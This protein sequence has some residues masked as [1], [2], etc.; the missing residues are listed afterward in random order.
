M[1]NTVLDCLGGNRGE[2]C[3]IRSMLTKSLPYSCMQDLFKVKSINQCRAFFFLC[4]QLKLREKERG[5]AKNRSGALGFDRRVKTKII[6][7]HCDA[8][9]LKWDFLK[10][11]PLKWECMLCV[12]ECTSS[13]VTDKLS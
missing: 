3:T 1:A 12:D 8:D 4:L 11:Y 6:S 9:P 10:K 5:K 2:A 7:E 13:S